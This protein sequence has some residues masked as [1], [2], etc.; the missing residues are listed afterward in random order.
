MV[1]GRRQPSAGRPR[2]NSPFPDAFAPRDAGNGYDE[3]REVTTGG[4]G[5]PRGHPSA[6]R[7]RSELTQPR[8]DSAASERPESKPVGTDAG[9]GH[10]KPEWN[11]DF[12]SGPSAL[13][14]PPP[15]TQLLGRRRASQ[16]ASSQ[17]LRVGVMP[18]AGSRRGITPENAFDGRCS[19]A[20]GSDASSS[21]AAAGAA[22]SGSGAGSRREGNRAVLAA[23]NGRAAANGGVALRD[24][25]VEQLWKQPD[26]NTDF[27]GPLL[28]PMEEPDPKAPQWFNEMRG[29]TGSSDRDASPLEERGGRGSASAPVQRP[30]NPSYSQQQAQQQRPQLQ[31]PQQSRRPAA[32]QQQQQQQ[33]A[34]AA[35]ESRGAK[36]VERALPSDN[37]GAKTW[38]TLAAEEEAAANGRGSDLVK[39][40]LCGRNF[41]FD[42]IEKHKVACA[43]QAAKPRRTFNAA[44]Q[45]LGEFAATDPQ[46]IDIKKAARED[47]RR[48]AVKAD[49]RRGATEP[50]FHPERPAARDAEPPPARKAPQVMLGK[51]GRPLSPLSSALARAK[52]GLDPEDEEEDDGASDLVPC[53][54][55]GR[56]FA[57]ERLATHLPI[58]QKVTMNSM[59]RSTWDARDQ[60]IDKDKI[61]ESMSP[62][63]LPKSRGRPG[64]GM[65]SST[66]VGAERWKHHTQVPVAA[67][68]ASHDD[69]DYGGR[70]GSAAARERNR[71]GSAGR[72][73]LRSERAERMG[74]AA[75]SSGGGGGF[76]GGGFGGGG[77]IGGGGG[78]GNVMPANKLPKWKR[79]HMAFQAAM[80]AC[81]QNSGAEASGMPLP[82]NLPPPPECDDRIPC[83]HCGR[84]FNALAA[85][86][87][88]PKCQAISAKPKT[89]TRGGG[90]QAVSSAS[91]Q[92]SGSSSASRGGR[93]YML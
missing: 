40:D 36:N 91:R 62:A 48:E 31:R 9:L 6:G 13:D 44:K 28:S 77:G 22:R 80:T 7:R 67:R 2:S 58:C 5:G 59:N 1:A 47:V 57:R 26:W 21:A 82:A 85:E 70:L 29:G 52:A 79:D 55:C 42:R 87:H 92:R 93:D 61:P 18:V 84:R 37:G 27:G 86:R 10:T 43:K 23:A 8:V 45:R 49:V 39:C 33:Q 56:N 64:N 17:Q 38:E 51:D 68:S 71:A 12:S 81:K 4:V 65:L 35:A 34:P 78:A 63:R 66:G 53:P 41:A 76:G 88:I 54:C 60:R 69:D 75:S 11:A 83:P 73:V 89:L 15:P 25:G 24:R 46:T 16:P 72:A 74:S 32:E 50:G 19:G 20:C 3:L 90:V 14:Q 30:Q